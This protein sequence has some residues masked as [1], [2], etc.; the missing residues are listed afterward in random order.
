MKTNGSKSQ[1][2]GI[3]LLVVFA[4]VLAAR[5]TRSETDS[6]KKIANVRTD[7]EFQVN[8]LSQEEA[9]PGKV[10]KA[11][12]NGVDKMN[13]VCKPDDA[14]IAVF[15]MREKKTGK[16]LIPT[17]EP[18]R[19]QAGHRYTCE[20]QS[21]GMI[22]LIALKRG[23]SSSPQYVEIPVGSDPSTSAKRTKIRIT[24][25]ASPRRV[26]PALE[27]KESSASDK[28]AKVTLYEN[29]GEVAVDFTEPIPEKEFDAATILAVSYAQFDPSVHGFTP[30]I[31]PTTIQSTDAIKLRI[32]RFA[33]VEEDK[34]LVYKGAKVIQANGKNFL[35]LP[36][37]EKIGQVMGF[38]LILGNH[39]PTEVASSSGKRAKSTQ[40]IVIRMDDRS[41]TMESQANPAPRTRRV[42]TIDVIGCEPS[43]ASLGIDSLKIQM[44]G[45]NQAQLVVD[46][47]YNEFYSGKPVSPPVAISIPELKIRIRVT[48]FKRTSTREM[49][50]PTHHSKTPNMDSN[51]NWA[52]GIS[53]NRSSASRF[54]RRSSVP[55]A[56]GASTA[57]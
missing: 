23:F 47:S 9:T 42:P 13:Y 24:K 31:C 35:S 22:H 2:F 30:F 3:A 49:L 46:G 20:F 56:Y 15:T 52:L 4:I 17:R 34:T 38:G 27:T 29:Q 54:S 25:I 43:A 5:F 26:L 45:V 44:V 51:P 18:C 32:E 53:E 7:P 16:D 11:T 40:E 14:A 37:E 55:I 50:F 41:R 39:L 33:A 10:I 36:I 1:V 19:D 8:V 57:R 12:L 48:T 21:F 6:P 28:I